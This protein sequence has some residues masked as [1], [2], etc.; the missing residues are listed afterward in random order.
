MLN[1]SFGFSSN[2]AGYGSSVAGSI[3][4]NGY[5]R[6]KMDKFANIAAGY[7]TDN[8]RGL[9]TPEP[10]KITGKVLELDTSAEGF[11]EPIPKIST[12]DELYKELKKQKEYYSP[13][14]RD[15]APKLEEVIER[16]ELKKFLWSLD[17]AEPEEIEIPHYGGK[18][19]KHTAVYETVFTVPECDLK[20]KRAILVFKGVDY[21]AEVFV[22]D[23][24]AGRHEGFFAPF[25]F[26][27]TEFI[28]I[29]NNRLKVIVKNDLVMMTD[30]NSEGV[31]I[32]GDKIY[33][34][35]GPGWDDP[36]VGWHHCPAGMGIY[37]KAYIELRE[38]EYITD[39][40]VREGKEL[41]IECM[42]MDVQ[43]KEVSFEVS[44]Y[45]QNFSEVVLEHEIMSPQ[46]LIEAGVGD[47][48][49]EA[50]LIAEGKLH[51]QTSLLLGNG[52]NRF[53]FE[54]EIPNPKQWSPD[55]PYLY[56][57]Q[58]KMLVEGKVTST[59]KRQFGIRTFTQDTEGKVK[60]MFYLNG[61]PLRLRGANTMGFEQQCVMQENYEQ[62]LDD[63]LLAK[64]AN[65]N[66]LRLTQRPV[67]EEIYELCDRIGLMIQTDL[68]LFGTVRINQMAETIRQAGEM[69]HLIRSHPCCI[70][71]TYINE[72]FP[73]AQN[74]PHRMLRRK[75]LQGLFE[76][77]DV[78]V[79]LHNPDRVIKHVDGDYDPPSDTLPDNHCYT[80][81]YN[82][83]GI[84][85]G[86][87]HKGY[88]LDVKPDWYWG[89]GEFGAEGLD[90]MEVMKESYP[91]E[92]IK[93]PF[94]PKN[95][96]K[97]QTGEF[98]YFFYDRQE[99]ME[100]WIK[101]SQE[102]QAYATK[103]M[104]NA[105]RR[106][107]YN[108]SFAIHLFIDAWPAGWMKA[109]MDCKRNPK[110]A[111]FSYRDCLAPVKADLRSDRMTWYG[112]EKLCVE[113]RICNDKERIEN[114]TVRIMIKA[115]EELIASGSTQAV[116]EE[117][118]TTYQGMINCILPQVKKETE[119]TVF[120]AI[121]KDG[122][123][124]HWTS[125]SFRVYPRKDYRI[126]EI[127]RWEHYKKNNE[128]INKEVEL[129]KTVVLEPLNPGNY[130]I[131]GHFIEVKSCGMAPVYFVS[132][133]T[134]HPLV[135]G[136][137]QK[138]FAYW[139]DVKEERMTPMISATLQTNEGI[140]VLTSGN[141]NSKGDWESAD[142]CLEIPYGKG[143]FIL[144]QLELNRGQTNPVCAEF[145]DRL[146]GY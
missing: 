62:L 8:S 42:G 13:F 28:E 96:L 53:Q 32:D 45:G 138:A 12:R 56:Q 16:I 47:T 97:A 31:N 109:I 135:D 94:D 3:E 83:H 79:R 24:F 17:G 40:F 11:F 69:E 110:Q 34:A 128:D 64:L 57:V 5:R 113:A 102:Y 33:A 36:Y 87:L 100:N 134:G 141:K 130:E 70:L 14:L 75:D 136:F 118:C 76:A 29:G 104:T 93:E 95:I 74:K 22:N 137:D 117:C 54:L 4:L 85:L 48:L 111:Y 38:K 59:M 145:A 49:T 112:G 66:F 51:Q 73:N 25:E 142:A 23:Q 2:T 80:M 146:A 127:I 21:I 103:V 90:F 37:Q 139:Y 126:P 106:C 55:S 122:E 121:E 46:V 105:M 77:A 19:G 123:Q 98:Y 58:V 9:I 108:V 92:W 86:R 101:E 72:P 119:I 88:W 71:V 120:M 35:T 140:S 52:F 132:S 15:L 18:I 78:M 61:K 81:W 131:A 116:I 115:G 114:A 39:L 67:Q 43:E 84:D 89:C 20:Q 7:K 44:V 26:D 133:K 143:R 125:E 91:K 30:T 129:G 50:E 68:P 60:G 99:T 6:I 63:M 10:E 65:M 27:V 1:E 41:W 107:N 144:C 82:G 124:L